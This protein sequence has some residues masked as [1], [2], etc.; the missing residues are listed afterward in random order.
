[1]PRRR[2]SSK[3]KGSKEQKQ[4]ENQ[5]LR[6][7]LIKHLCEDKTSKAAQRALTT[8]GALARLE[9]A[10]MNSEDWLED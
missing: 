2:T 9:D 5:P 4:M 8:L 6:D 7:T 1:M 10:Y 3:L